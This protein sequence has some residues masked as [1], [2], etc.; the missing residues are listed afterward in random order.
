MIAP[1]DDATLRIKAAYDA[2]DY[3]CSAYPSSHPDRLATVATLLGVN[4]PALATSRVLEIG[5]ADGSN[6]I[7]IA[8]AWPD[9]FVVGCDLSPRPI[10]HAKRLAD[11]IGLRNLTLLQTDIRALPEELGSFDYIIA[12]GFYSWVPSEVRDALMALI[13]ARLTPNGVAYVSYNAL[14]GSRI[15]Q[16]AWDALHFHTD[17]IDDARGKIEAARTLMQLLAEPQLAQWKAD[18]QLRAEF[19]D[20]AVRHESALFHDDISTPNDAFYFHEFEAHARRHGLTFLSEAESRFM[21]GSGLTPAMKRMVA[22]CDRITREQY[23]DFARFRRFRV[24]LLTKAPSVSNYGFIPGRIANLQVAAAATLIRSMAEAEQQGQ[25]RESVLREGE[26][27]VTRMLLWLAELSPRTVS[28]ADIVAWLATQQA[29][30]DRRP[31][32]LLLTEVYIG[33][34]I[35]FY[36]QPAA[37]TTTVSERPLASPVA[38]AMARTQAR[39]VNLR[40]EM[41]NLSDPFARRLVPLLDGTRNRRTL[42]EALGSDY[43]RG[44]EGLDAMLRFFGK[45]SLLAG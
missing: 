24:S 6:I 38:R 39:V 3:Q 4:P 27:L 31:I 25:P 33:G 23:L 20:L 34:V 28:V 7:P 22:Q 14:P 32:E 12:H 16:I 40:H 45:V 41:V 44:E 19:A 1:N 8:A 42:I 17:R 13:A 35:E 37:L 36:V 26:P 43:D 21:G 18:G 29:P 5:C 2:V 9:A 15:R 30:N 10:E 11:E